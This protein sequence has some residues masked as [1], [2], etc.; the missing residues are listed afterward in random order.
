MTPMTTPTLIALLVLFTLVAGFFSWW[1]AQA[2]IGST[3]A[4]DVLRPASS[5]ASG[6]HLAHLTAEAARLGYVHAWTGQV[7]PLDYAELHV[8]RTDGSMLQ[9][10]VKH[11]LMEAKLLYGFLQPVEGRST[12]VTTTPFRVLVND[13]SFAQTFVGASLSELHTRHR[14]AVSFLEASGV[15]VD[16]SRPDTAQADFVTFRM[17]LAETMR[18]TTPLGLYLR[19]IA[20]QLRLH[21]ICLGPL[22][23]QRGIERKVSRIVADCRPPRQ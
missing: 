7:D 12:W 2:R 11:V 21:R 13:R 8:H 10:G 3:G 23:S 6:A 5:P 19:S 18:T 9:M 1:R 22:E 14:Q 17:F 16:R 20:S 4:P 15:N